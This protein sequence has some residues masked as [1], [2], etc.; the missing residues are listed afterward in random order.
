MLRQTE[1]RECVARR[2]EASRVDGGREVESTVFTHNELNRDIICLTSSTRSLALSLD[3]K[4]ER[5]RK[6]GNEWRDEESERSSSSH[7]IP[8]MNKERKDSL[9]PLSVGVAKQTS[10]LKPRF[11][12]TQFVFAFSSQLEPSCWI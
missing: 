7:Q 4:N 11:A 9:K 12:S 2:V 8:R 3:L 10:H 1:R 5:E 6:R